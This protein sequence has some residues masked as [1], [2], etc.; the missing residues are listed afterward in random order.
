MAEGTFSSGD[1]E[2]TILN[3]KHDR[4]SFEVQNPV[5]LHLVNWNTDVGKVTRTDSNR[6]MKSASYRVGKPWT[7]PRYELES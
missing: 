2:N 1:S 6:Q 5:S 4:N 3:F 7:R